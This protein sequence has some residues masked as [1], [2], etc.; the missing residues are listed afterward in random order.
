M[1][2][3][4]LP[5]VG[6]YLGRLLSDTRT[7]RTFGAHKTGVLRPAKPDIDMQSRHCLVKKITDAE[8]ECLTKANK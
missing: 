7:S 6:I 5:A 4:I 1:S 2:R 3:M 8:N